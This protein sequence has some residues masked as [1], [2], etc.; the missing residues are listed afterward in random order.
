MQVLVTNSYLQTSIPGGVY[1][2]NIQLVDTKIND[3]KKGL[4]NGFAQ[5]ILHELMISSQYEEKQ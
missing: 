4:R 5:Q 3:N 2:E 1:K